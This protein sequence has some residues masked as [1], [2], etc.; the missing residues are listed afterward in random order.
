M[1]KNKNIQRNTLIALVLAAIALTFLARLWLP[2][3]YNFVPVGALALFAGAYF[4]SLKWAL[5]VPVAA[6]FATDSILHLQYVLGGSEWPGY[7][8]LLPI[9]YFSYLLMV[10]IGSGLRGRINI[11][12]VPLS[13]IA[14]SILFFIV[15]NFGVW[16]MGGYTYTFAG[17][18]E[19]YTLAIPFFR[20]TLLGNL[21]YVGVLFGSYEMIKSYKAVLGTS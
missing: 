21:F 12:N 13:A 7:H 15:T 14:G 6:M 4:R 2:A 10:L 5:L 19:C 16:A 1:S 9:V 20:S 17:L 11:I 8:T 18:V 3:P